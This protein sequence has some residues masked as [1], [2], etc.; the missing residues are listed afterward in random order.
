MRGLGSRSCPESRGGRSQEVSGVHGVCLQ[1]PGPR[2]HGR[3]S[4][5]PAKVRS[6]ACWEASC[7]FL[8]KL[9]KLPPLSRWTEQPK[10][11]APRERVGEF[12]GLRSAS[13]WAH[14]AFLWVPGDTH[15]M[16][17]EL[18][19]LAWPFQTFQCKPISTYNKKSVK[20]KSSHPYLSSSCFKALSMFILCPTRVTPRS[21]RSSFCRF[22]K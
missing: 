8:P 20:V 7:E 4:P 12:Q 10:K 9:E 2:A 18:P 22:G 15:G 14:P 13:S 11:S 17:V 19:D 3:E 1:E 5:G 6:P 21:I 16:G